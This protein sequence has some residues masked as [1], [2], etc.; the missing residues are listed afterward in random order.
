[1][2]HHDL[3]IACRT[4]LRHIVQMDGWALHEEGEMIRIISPGGRV[5]ANTNCWDVALRSLAQ[6]VDIPAVRL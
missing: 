2:R 4:A 3:E 6:C 5:V 1:M